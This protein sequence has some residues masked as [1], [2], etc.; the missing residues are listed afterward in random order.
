ALMRWGNSCWPA[1]Y[2][3]AFLVNL[4]ID[5]SS[6]LLAAGIAVG[7]TLG[8]LLSAWLLRRLHFRISMHRMQDIVYLVFS[9]CLGMLVSA[10]GGVTALV[11][12]SA[13]NV[14]AATGA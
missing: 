4:S 11:H 5:P 2:V 6:P 8:P 9:A 12:F 7:N 10:V 14:D 1:I 13:M 3:G